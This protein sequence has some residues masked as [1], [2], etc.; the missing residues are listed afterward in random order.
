M[1]KIQVYYKSNY[2]NVLCYPYCERAKTF[3]RLT[4]Y[5]TFNDYHL[6]QIKQ[7]GYDIE[8]IALSVQEMCRLHG[9]GL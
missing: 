4:G 6:A 7:L 2:G 8:N 1:K 5:K 3:I 9:E